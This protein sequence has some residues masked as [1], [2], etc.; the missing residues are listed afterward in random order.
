MDKLKLYDVSK[1]YVAFLQ[2]AEIEARGFTR[3]PNMEYPGREQKFLCGIVMEING[4]QYYVAATSY[5]K[6]QSENILIVFPDDTYSPIK[7]SLRFNFMFPVPSE[8]VT[9]RII[10]HE[11]K[12]SRRIFLAKQLEFFNASVDKIRQKAT[13]TYNKVIHRYSPSLTEQSCD[14]KLLEAKCLEY[15]LLHNLKLSKQDQKPTPEQTPTKKPSVHDRLEAAKAQ[16]A[17]RDTGQGSPQPQHKKN[18]PER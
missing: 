18:A 1:E 3:V 10:D 7:G 12:F 16:T 14:F 6:Q 4:V 5:K 15:C 8:A 9:M 11:P 17:Q 13:H 2:A